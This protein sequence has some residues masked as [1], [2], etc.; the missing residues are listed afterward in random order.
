[1]KYS[2]KSIIL[3]TTAL[4]ITNASAFTKNEIKIVPSDKIGA[5]NCSVNIVMSNPSE[6]VEKVDDQQLQEI[7]KTELDKKS[8]SIATDDKATFKLQVEVMQ[9]IAQD[10][11]KSKRRAICKLSKAYFSIPAAKV[12]LQDASTL[13][14]LKI[15][16]KKTDSE[17]LQKA[18]SKAIKKALHGMVECRTL[19]GY[20]F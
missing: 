6:D 1:M 19:R 18:C 4:L 14:E 12:L 8:Y 3:L 13:S 16:T 9:Y 10:S 7:I 2:I 17:G 15:P 20:N 5:A 11:S